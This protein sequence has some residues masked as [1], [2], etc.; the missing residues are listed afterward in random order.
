[1]LVFL[2]WFTSVAAASFASWESWEEDDKKLRDSPLA[3]MGRRSG[4]DWVYL[5]VFAHRVC[6][7]S[8][9]PVERIERISRR[10]G[11]LSVEEGEGRQVDFLVGPAPF[12]EAEIA[13][14][15]EA[16]IE[17]FDLNAPEPIGPGIYGALCL[18][19]HAAQH[20]PSKI[21][22]LMVEADAG[23]EESSDKQ[24]QYQ[25][26]QLWLVALGLFPG[27]RLVVPS[28]GL[29]DYTDSLVHGL[30]GGEAESRRG[31]IEQNRAVREEMD[32]LMER[33]QEDYGWQRIRKKL[34]FFPTVAYPMERQTVWIVLQGAEDDPD[35]LSAH[36]TRNAAIAYATNIV[37]HHEPTESLWIEE[38]EPLPADLRALVVGAYLDAPYSED[39]DRRLDFYYTN[40]PELFWSAEENAPA[41]IILEREDRQGPRPKVFYVPANE[42]LEERVVV[43][44]VHLDDA[45][46]Y[47]RRGGFEAIHTV[48]RPTSRWKMDGPCPE[49]YP[50]W[51]GDRSGLERWISAVEQEEHVAVEDLIDLLERSYIRGLWLTQHAPNPLFEQGNPADWRA[52]LPPVEISGECV[53]VRSRD[54][55]EVSHTLRIRP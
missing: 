32:R 3:R 13:T 4:W 41:R 29:P 14:L 37:D 39:L 5:P 40:S 38:T 35:V 1:M 11:I 36:A 45:F 46:D 48:H 52:P 42:G 19:R 43:A 24:L 8:V 7:D 44:F 17:G 22:R 12:T 30:R 28:D 49:H 23:L 15:R 31:D 53:V 51:D 10:V 25:I 18:I 20:D 6:E 54:L 9:F 33:L 21:E 27:Q 34:G 47:A 50:D 26:L 2:S 55:G 16:S